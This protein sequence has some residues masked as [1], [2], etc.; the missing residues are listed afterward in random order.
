MSNCVQPGL[1]RLPLAIAVIAAFQLAPAFA[2]DQ[3]PTT[4][5]NQSSSTDQ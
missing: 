2:Q 3:A 1:R 5:T 4:G